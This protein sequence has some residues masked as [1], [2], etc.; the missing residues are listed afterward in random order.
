MI[1]LP[2]QVFR[3]KPKYDNEFHFIGKVVGP[4]LVFGDRSE[5]TE[6]ENAKKV[7]KLPF[8]TRPRPCDSSKRRV[9]VCWSVRTFDNADLFSFF[10]ISK[11]S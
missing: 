7:L 4:N 2:E 1:L 5:N 6:E 10:C 11:E 3:G 8:S 9:T